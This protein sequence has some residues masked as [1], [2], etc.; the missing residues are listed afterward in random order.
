MS[1]RLIVNCCVR[2]PYVVKN[3]LGSTGRYK[4]KLY[5]SSET[6]VRVVD[7]YFDIFKETSITSSPREVNYSCSWPTQSWVSTSWENDIVDNIIL[8]VT[9]SYKIHQK[10]LFNVHCH[11]HHQLTI[12]TECKI[13]VWDTCFLWDTLFNKT[14]IR[15]YILLW[16]EFVPVASMANNAG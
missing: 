3:S 6:W 16:L 12:T 15:Y 2:C 11:S 5:S 9:I 14:F 13:K 7:I 4:C 1:A 8:N 10:C